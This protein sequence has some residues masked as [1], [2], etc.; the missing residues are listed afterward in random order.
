VGDVHE[1][2]SLYPLCKNRCPG[3]FL[4]VSKGQ[5]LVTEKDG[6]EMQPDTWQN[7]RILS[8]LQS[9]LRI[10]LILIGGQL[11]WPPSAVHA[12]E[13][14]ALANPTA[15]SPDPI[16]SSAKDSEPPPARASVSVSATARVLAV[17]DA[18]ATTLFQPDL[19][20]VRGMIDRGLLEFTGKSTRQE[21]WAQLI[22]SSDVVGFKV[23]SSPGPVSGTRPSVVQALVESLLATGHQPNQIVIWDKRRSDL[24]RSGFMSLAAQ[25]GVRCVASD[26]VGWD[27]DWHYESP[28]IGRL[29][30]GDHEFAR[31][32]ETGTG[33]RSY[34]SR[35]ITKDLTKIVTV[36]P[37]LNHSQLGI[38]GQLANLALGGIDNTLRFEQNHQMLAEVIPEICVLEPL[39]TRWAFGVS[40]ALICQYRGEE[41][42]LLH[43]AT[44]L[45]ELRFS[46]DPVALDVL[47]L[48]D[49]QAARSRNPTQG[50]RPMKIALF[51]NAEII[52]LG[53]ARSNRIEVV[54]IP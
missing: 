36:T 26:S 39:I 45:N 47:A 13:P 21:A 9:M 38:N 29:V 35:L 19:E 32:H 20:V 1:F 8:P 44:A 12:D 42:A 34:V 27:D 7:L 37:V 25:L 40:D 30:F 54:R 11:S 53:M 51:E 46:L 33:R 43:Y 17:R 22:H 2:G 5:T 14:P 28:V 15:G 3:C 48:Q 18:A 23:V 10:L 16:H 49:V 50:E 52:E 4:G 6:D 24:E 31:R 41:R